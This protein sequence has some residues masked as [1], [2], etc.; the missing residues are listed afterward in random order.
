MIERLS[1]LQEVCLVTQLVPVDLN[2]EPR[3]SSLVELPRLDRRES[4]Y[5]FLIVLFEVE[6]LLVV[7]DKEVWW[8]QVSTLLL[9][10]PLALWVNSALG[11]SEP[12]HCIEIAG[13][14]S[15][16][17]VA[18][19]ACR[20]RPI[21]VN[22]ETLP[23]NT[24]KTALRMVLKILEPILICWYNRIELLKILL[25]AFV[26]LHLSVSLLP[27]DIAACVDSGPF[28]VS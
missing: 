10:I 3:R 5:A 6:V 7:V 28:E 22:V 20:L 15:E 4:I 23:V 12:N 26:D 2:R 14:D 18:I 21:Y 25:R 24:L 13:H 9:E 1:P 27:V 19:G 8:A 11:T 16:V 17:Y